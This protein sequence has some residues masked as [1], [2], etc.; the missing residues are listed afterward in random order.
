MSVILRRRPHET[1][2]SAATPKW[3]CRR[4][5]KGAPTQSH[6]KLPT[7]RPALLPNTHIFNAERKQGSYRYHLY[8]SFVMSRSTT[9]PPGSV[10]FRKS[11]L[12]PNIL[13]R[14][15]VSKAWHNTV[16]ITYSWSFCSY[17]YGIFIAYRWYVNGIILSYHISYY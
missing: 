12:M 7:G 3:Y 1:M 5:L 15:Q 11:P 8:T 16:P 10:H 13:I 4:H 9:E 14:R 17:I 6:Y 2:F